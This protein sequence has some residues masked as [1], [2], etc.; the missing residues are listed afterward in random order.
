[1]TCLEDSSFGYELVVAAEALR[2]VFEPE[3]PKLT[4]PTLW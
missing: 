3:L 1:M 4:V 2:Q